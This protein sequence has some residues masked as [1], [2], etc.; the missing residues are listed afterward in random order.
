M[1]EPTEK[2]TFASWWDKTGLVIEP[3]TD[4][5]SAVG[6]AERVS[7]AAWTA[8]RTEYL[9]RIKKLEKRLKQ[10]LT[11]NPDWDRLAAAEESLREHMRL[12]KNARARIE[13]VKM[14]PRYAEQRGGLFV[15]D[16]RHNFDDE[17]LYMCVYDVLAA[18]KPGE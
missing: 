6:H 12:L 2:L 16:S 18:L 4:R 9:G 3:Y 13:S 17:E 1:S 10:V 11:F 15:T 14:L 5:N 8:C 7:E